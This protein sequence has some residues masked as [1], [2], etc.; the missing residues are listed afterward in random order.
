MWEYI[1]CY[2]SR[3]GRQAKYLPPSLG[4][5]KKNSKLKIEGNI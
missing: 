2:G 1:V 3:R 5:E 4:F